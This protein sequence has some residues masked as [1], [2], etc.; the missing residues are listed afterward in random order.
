[1][2]EVAEGEVAAAAALVRAAKEGAAAR[3]VPRAGEVGQGR[4]WAAAH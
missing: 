1:V 4:T 2:L 3:R